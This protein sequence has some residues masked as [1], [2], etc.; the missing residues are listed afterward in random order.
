MVAVVFRNILGKKRINTGR[1]K[2]FCDTLGLPRILPLIM[3]HD[4]CK[5]IYLDRRA[6]N[7]QTWT[8]K[9]P[10]VGGRA[11]AGSG[12]SASSDTRSGHDE[13]EQNVRSLLS[14]FSQGA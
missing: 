14:V 13:V 11:R 9:S 6:S 10:P 5:V 8:N 4:G 2:G 1:R 7:E 12:S 3:D